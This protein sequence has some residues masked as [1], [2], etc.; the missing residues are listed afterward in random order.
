[1]QAKTPFP[2]E[3]RLHHVGQTG[4]KYGRLYRTSG[5]KVPNLLFL[6]HFEQKVQND[7]VKV[8]KYKTY[9]HVKTTKKDDVNI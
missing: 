1:M 9:K 6:H 3:R 7:A 5:S 8:R 4:S 2:R